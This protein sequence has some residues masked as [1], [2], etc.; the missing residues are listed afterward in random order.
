MSHGTSHAW[1]NNHYLF[2]ALILLQHL[3]QR[4]YDCHKNHG[5][6]LNVFSTIVIINKDNVIVIN[7]YQCVT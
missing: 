2:L 5:I 3:V 4:I 1:P 6:S 7:T